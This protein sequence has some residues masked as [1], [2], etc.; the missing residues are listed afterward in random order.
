M[1]SLS[2]LQLAPDDAAQ[3]QRVAQ[4]LLAA[5]VYVLFAGVH[6]IEVAL[7][8]VDAFAV[9]LL[10]AVSLAG[11]AVFH[12]LVRRRANLRWSHPARVAE[13]QCVFGVACAVWAYAI[14]GPTRGAVL[15]IL[16][17]ILVFGM[18]AL[19]PVAARRVGLLSV[20]LLGLA[21]VCGLRLEADVEAVHFLY[22]AVAVAVVLVLSERLAGMRDTLLAQ[23]GQLEQ[24]LNRLSEQAV[25]DELTGLY[26]RRYMMNRLDQELAHPDRHAGAL[27]V[28]L[29]DIDRFKEINDR[30]GHRVG[31]AVLRA[32]GLVASSALRQG[33]VVARWGGEEFLILLPLTPDA[34]AVSAIDRLRTVLR[35]HPVSVAQPQLRVTFSAGLAMAGP[36]E[37]AEQIIERADLAMYEA[38]RAGRD[39]TVVSVSAHPLADRPQGP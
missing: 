15:V 14:H 23:K 38:K 7:H 26:N 24:L 35:D 9:R 20:A 13:L 17:V 1:P 19:T 27:A 33:D 2:S 39:R 34:T 16:L 10:T 31:D 25:R 30:Y 36:G 22:A 3:Q 5:W 32:V 29:I 18:F 11:A 12:L 37:R 8:L 4:S 6:E 28:V 21:I